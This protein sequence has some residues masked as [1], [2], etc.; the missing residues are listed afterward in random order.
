MQYN[1]TRNKGKN[2]IKLSKIDYH[3]DNMVNDCSYFLNI[4][5]KLTE[6]GREI[7]KLLSNLTY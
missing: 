4:M 1:F 2:T 3:Y 7:N 5:N 6:K